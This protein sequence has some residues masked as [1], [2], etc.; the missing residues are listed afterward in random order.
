MINMN[1]YIITI[2]DELL[3]GHVVNPNAAYIGE[4]LT[5][6]RIKVIGSSVVPDN[7]EKIIKEFKRAYKQSDIIIGTGG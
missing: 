1:A 2:G 4:Q 6:H 3:I 5:E 7:E